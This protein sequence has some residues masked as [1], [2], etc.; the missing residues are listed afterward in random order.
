[1]RMA[2]RS[3]ERRGNRVTVHAGPPGEGERSYEFDL[4]DGTGMPYAELGIDFSEFGDRDVNLECKIMSFNEDTEEC[5][6]CI[7]LPFSDRTYQ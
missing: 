6:F 5:V 7:I 1:M 3:V 2:I 4:I